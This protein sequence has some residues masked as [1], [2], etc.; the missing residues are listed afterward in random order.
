MLSLEYACYEVE[1]A[2]WLEIIILRSPEKG[3]PWK[4]WLD[5]QFPRNPKLKQILK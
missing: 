5:P 2:T 1:L 3:I 4:F